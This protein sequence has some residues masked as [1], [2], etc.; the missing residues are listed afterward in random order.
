VRLRSGHADGL[1]VI[2]VEFVFVNEVVVDAI[3]EVTEGIIATFF[4]V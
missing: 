2:I 1:V 4:V 3:I